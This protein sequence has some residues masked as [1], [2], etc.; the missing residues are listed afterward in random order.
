MRK[1]INCCK[2]RSLSKDPAAPILAFKHYNALERRIHKLM[3]YIFECMEKHPGDQLKS[4]IIT[5]FHN[6][7]V[8][9]PMAGEDID[10]SEEESEDTANANPPAPQDENKRDHAAKKDANKPA[11]AKANTDGVGIKVRHDDKIKLSDNKSTESHTPA[12]KTVIMANLA[13]P[14]A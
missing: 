13:A 14:P 12:P 2:W 3:E 5:E 9:E 6:D 10:A 1:K 11:D 4:M 7:D 8:P